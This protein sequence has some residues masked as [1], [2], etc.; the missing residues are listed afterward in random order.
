MIIPR[1]PHFTSRGDASLVGGGAYCPRLEFWFDVQWGARIISGVNN[2]KPSD[3]G[4]VHINSLEFIV[5]ILQLAAIRT[6]MESPAWALYFPHGVPDIPVWL[7]ETDNTV[8]NSWATRVSAKG[9]QGQGLVAIYSEL[10]RTT[11]LHTTT[12]HLAGKLNVVADD[13]SRN[14]FSLSPRLRVQRLVNLH[15]L[16]ADYDYFHPS[17]E[18]ARDLSSHLYSGPST[19]HYELPRV[20]GQFKPAHSTDYGS[21]TI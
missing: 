13:I 15:P 5:V 19:G 8:S 11:R 20:L 10:L 1:V 21:F 16:L 2:C 18:L 4:Y 17:P 6:R 7:G 14:D 12:R 3:P 9:S